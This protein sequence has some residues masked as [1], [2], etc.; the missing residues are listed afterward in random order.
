MN[1]SKDI[2]ENKILPHLFFNRKGNRLFDSAK[3]YI[4][5][6]GTDIDNIIQGL[7]GVDLNDVTFWEKIIEI[8]S[9][10]YEKE[11]NKHSLIEL[12]KTDTDKFF[13]KLLALRF[14]YEFISDDE[15]LLMDTDSIHSFIA[16]HLESQDNLIIK[17]NGQTLV[18]LVNSKSEK[19]YVKPFQ[20]GELKLYPI[21]LI[22]ID[23]ENKKISLNG[24][25]KDR[26]RLIAQINNYDDGIINKENIEDLLSFK[27]DVSNLFSVLS[28][29]GLYLKN[30][31]FDCSFFKLNISVT[32]NNI[33]EISEFINPE[34]ILHDVS[35]F[36]KI[37]QMQFDYYFDVEKNISFNLVVENYYQKREGVD[38]KYFK[39]ILK[40]T[41]RRKDIDL[42]KIE[43]SII[44][45]LNTIG[46]E[47]NKY[48]LQNDW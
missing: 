16:E 39:I 9:I 42:S 30:V 43:Q 1:F 25:K 4:E 20:P 5:Q 6:S 28:D 18:F 17:D 40:T 3:K 45:E 44:K 11:I 12:L 36:L 37:K 26:N 29:K 19:T 33:L 10:V 47:I 46:I 21:S 32:G 7:K 41:S 31:K 24:Y 13:E 48:P 22:K 15:V 34:L 14:E 27:F 23:M 35:D 8:L 38:E 2:V